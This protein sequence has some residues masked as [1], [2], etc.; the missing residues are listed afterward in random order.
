[1]VAW[2]LLSGK[3]KLLSLRSNLV[4]T[5]GQHL[6]ASPNLLKFSPKDVLIV[7]C[8]PD[9]SIKV[10]LPNFTAILFSFP[11]RNEYSSYFIP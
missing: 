6:E 5:L 9:G 2:S 7:S 11:D 10:T 3:V 4:K 8:S 1:M